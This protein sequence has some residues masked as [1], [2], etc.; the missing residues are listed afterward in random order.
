MPF[1]VCTVFN[2]WWWTERQSETCRV[3]L[4]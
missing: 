2:C 1:A 3:L 4:Q